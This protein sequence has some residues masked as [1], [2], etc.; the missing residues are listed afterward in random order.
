MHSLHKQTCAN[1]GPIP[2]NL[3]NRHM[4]IERRLPHIVLSVLTL[5]LIAGCGGGGSSA[6]PAPPPPPPVDTTAPTVAAVQAPAANVNR[7]V[8]LTA[9][10]T[11]SVGVTAVRFFVDGVLLGS[12]TAAPYSMAWDTSGETE[13]DHTLTAEAEDAAGNI[14][15]SAAATVTVQNIVQFAVTLSGQEEVPASDTQASAQ[16]TFMINL[17]SGDVQG[18]LTATGLN[19]T[20]AHIHDAFA[21]TNGSVLIPLD[22]DAGDPT[23]FTAPVGALL[24]PA[25]V[26]L[27]LAGGLYAN[28][29]SAAAPGGEI[30]GQIL[31]DGFVLRFTDLAGIASVPRV[32]SLA[33]G[34]AAVTLDQVNGSIVVHAQVDGL[35]DSTV[36]HVHQAYAGDAGAVLVPLTKDPLDVGHWSAEGMALNAAGLDAFAN[37][38]L[39]V[40]VHSPANP[41]GEI[42]GQILPDG[43]KVIF[44]GLSGEERVPIVDTLAEGLVALTLDEA[45]ALVTI[46]VN[47]SGIDDANNAHLHGAYAGANG[48]VEVGLAQDGSDPSHWFIEEAAITTEQLD[49]LLAGATYVNVHSPANPGGEIR[50]QV[51]P[52]GIVFAFGRL[53]GDQRVPVVVTAA[54]GTFAVT[55]DPAVGT[56]VAHAN[57]VGIVDPTVAHIHDGYAGTNGGVAVPLV[58][59]PA[60][61]SHWSA[62]DAPVTADQQA[63]LRSG[64]YYLNVHTVVNGGGEIRGQLAPSPVEVLHTN[65]SGDQEIPTTG[66]VATAI[67]ASTIDLEAG[68]VTL[69]MNAVGADLATASHIHLGYAG[70][71]GGVLIPLVQD[72][73]DL[74]HWSVDAAALD[75]AGLANYRAGQ[76]YVNLHTP[77]NPG[78]EIR[79]QI[80]PPPI[81]VLF[82][83]MSGADEVPPVTTTATAIAAST[84]DREAGVVTLH[85][86]ASGAVD[87]TASHIH[88]GS[89][90]QNG[91]VLIPLEQDAVNLDH[92]SVTDARLDSAGIA[93]YRGGQLY[94][95]LHTLVN[96]GGEVRGQIVPPDAA[97]FDIVA[98]TA[99]LTSSGT[100]V[101]GTVTLTADASDDQGVVEVRFL[102]DAALIGIDT[103][104]P[105]SF[106]WDTTGVV[107]GDVTLT[108]EADDAAGN[109]GVS[110]DVV[111]TVQNAAPVTLSEL[112]TQIFTPTCSVSGCHSGPTSNVLPSGMNLTSTANS[113]AA[114]VNV[115]SLQVALD[116]VE[117][118][119]PDNSYLIQ[120]LEGGP[121]ITRMPQGGPFLDQATINM[122]RQWIS[123]DAPNN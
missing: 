28:V 9:T 65:L 25:G 106:D 5:L 20:A 27:L 26:D 45:G 67:A 73:V 42:R 93:S 100:P 113:F 53:S 71:N 94:V 1:A 23:I 57:T 70:E 52:E 82:T 58:L 6:A 13:G 47:S 68:T 95:N 90:G 39:Y 79:G 12:D 120:K 33:S 34:R 37:G 14:G 118:G 48:G 102:V 61:N 18:N 31:P 108:A 35:D 62:I 60:D 77:A 15:T 87:Q 81:E 86:N 74:G 38:Q 8:T 2:K 40:N 97:D 64:R 115:P 80:A 55:L 21:G 91:P 109:I 99:T 104:A 105:Y 16:A 123:D 29:H 66:S 44:A 10:A 19:P 78:G 121:G 85:L 75:D 24:D 88:T 83:V 51:I 63:A 114:L 107:N 89:A 69:H 112:Q 56:L 59:D 116:R 43:I 84:I 122:V 46:H 32:H 50:G 11:D 72:A 110:A 7:T 96:T 111:V 101:S 22:Q 4:T 54:T 41:G 17:A 119:D 76:L 117:P 92:W 103:S 3:G 36:A 49:A 98:P 30:R